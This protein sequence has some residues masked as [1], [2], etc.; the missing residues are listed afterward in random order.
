MKVKGGAVRSFHLPRET[1]NLLVGKREPFK[2]VAL[3]TA[4]GGIRKLTNE[5]SE[6][7][8]IRCGYSVHDCRHY[9]AIRLFSKTHDVYAVE[10]ALGHATR[11]DY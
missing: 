4:Q 8:V 2:G 7:G 6:R 5:L 1:E 3:S 9:F 11:D 10:E